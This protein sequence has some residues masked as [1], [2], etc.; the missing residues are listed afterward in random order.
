MSGQGS[1]LKS[2][3]AR[4]LHLIKAFVA[5]LNPYQPKSDSHSPSVMSVRGNLTEERRVRRKTVSEEEHRSGVKYFTGRCQRIV[6]ATH[7]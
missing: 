6:S 2:S 5:E 3:E 4:F 7:S 1:A